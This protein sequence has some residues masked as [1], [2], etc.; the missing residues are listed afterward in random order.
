MNSCLVYYVYLGY[1]NSLGLKLLKLVIY[2][3]SQSDLCLAKNM[4]YHEMTKLIN[5]RLNFIRD[6]IEQKFLH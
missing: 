3:D 6:V 1:I 2:Y 5:V 4:V